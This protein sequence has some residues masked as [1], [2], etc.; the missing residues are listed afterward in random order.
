MGDKQ[1]SAGSGKVGVEVLG[2]S[3]EV[4]SL[5][6]KALPGRDFLAHPSLAERILDRLIASHDPPR[7]RLLFFVLMPTEI[8]AIT[9][10]ERGLSVSSITRAFSHILS[11]WIRQAQSL[12]GSVFDGPY[13]ASPMDSQ[14]ALRRE[15]LMLARR[16]VKL[17]LCAST[18]YYAHSALPLLMGLKYSET[19]DASPLLSVFGQTWTQA[20]RSLQSYLRRR[21]TEEDWRAWELV[22][23][24]RMPDTLQGPLSGAAVG[25][26][27]SA[28]AAELIAAGGG[29]GIEG[30]LALLETWVCAKISPSHL[31]DL[32][33]ESR[34]L[35]AVRGRALVACLAVD[36]QLCSAAFVARHFGRSKGT[37]SEQMAKC[38]R[39]R[40]R[41]RLILA[42]PLQRI[43]TESNEL[44]RAGRRLDIPTNP[45]AVAETH[46]ERNG[47]PSVPLS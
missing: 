15:T 11:R 40:A 9:Q 12:R 20:R 35:Q 24:L 26:H 8:H 16:P 44:K 29:Y 30:A 38:R 28:A 36:H 10:I 37:T 33:R 46:P 27:L 41:D 21:P 25:G 13:R 31:L 45:A 23:E 39:N 6:W 17:G 18:R 19:F 34:A 1:T 7:T 14:E 4:W 3:T 32:H 2:P 42:T 22:R 47:S 43:I 5:S